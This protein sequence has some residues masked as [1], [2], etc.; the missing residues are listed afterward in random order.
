VL[1]LQARVWVVE[2]ELTAR[3]HRAPTRAE[4][5]ASLGV[6]RV[7][8]DEAMSL[9]ACFA[10]ASLDVASDPARP[11]STLG[12]RLADSEDGYE[13]TEL[14][15]CL[16]TALGTLSERDR[17]I[18]CLRFVDGLTQQEIGDSL[19]VSQMQVSRLLHRILRDLRLALGP[20]IAA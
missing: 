6:S 5:A 7:E 18:V 4:V 11:E 9:G 8:V 20:A 17:R 13:R 10:P 12:H 2:E 14:L 19:H 1:E 3:L 15:L 16:D